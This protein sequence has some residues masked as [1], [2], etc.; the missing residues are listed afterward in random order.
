[1]T[2][3][4]LFVSIGTLV[5]SIATLI[6]AAL[7]LRSVR[8]SVELGEDRLRFLEA[9][10]NRLEL[11]GEEHRRLEGQLEREHQERLGAQQRVQ[12]LEEERPEKLTW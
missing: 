12:Q 8:K 2:E 1:V 3:A 5:L 9:E 7:A 4:L 11:L 6:T 10:R